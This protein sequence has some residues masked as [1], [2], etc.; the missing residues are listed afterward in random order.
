MKWGRDELVGLGILLAV[1]SV[2]ALA[3]VAVLAECLGWGE[4]TP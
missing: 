1:L 4:I 2:L 3:V